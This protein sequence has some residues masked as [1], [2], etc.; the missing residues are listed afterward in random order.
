MPRLLN[1]CNSDGEALVILVYLL[2]TRTLNGL[3]VFL[4][5]DMQ[6]CVWCLS[7]LMGNNYVY[8]KIYNMKNPTRA[9]YGGAVLGDLYVMRLYVFSNRCP[10]G[11]TLSKRA[12]RVR[13]R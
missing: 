6:G 7:W 12:W 1:S 8:V 9:S 2:I 13:G 10:L 3:G 11:L 4:Q 5:S